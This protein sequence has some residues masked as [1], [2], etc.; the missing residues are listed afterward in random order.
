M[1]LQSTMYLHNS[2]SS[3][4]K[5]LTAFVP[6]TMACPSDNAG[7]RTYDHPSIQPH[8]TAKGNYGA[9]FGNMNKGATR[10]LAANHLP[11]AFGYR[12]VRLANITDGTS[13]SMAFG[14]QLRGSRDPAE[15]IRGSYWYD[16]PGGAWI[17][18]FVGPN[19]PVPDSL[20]AS[21]CP[22]ASNKPHLNLP[23]VPVNGASETVASRS[24]HP[25][26]LQVT[27]CDGSVRYISNNI[28]LN[29]WR[30]SGSIDAG[31]ATSP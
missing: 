29:E 16:F 18:T 26:G 10:T 25:N 19:S 6:P 27:L 7:S 8:I 30:A 23:C 12:P 17:F 24:R 15:S 5:S 20:R 1:G 3:G 9:F 14:E 13:N 2:N 31:E 28:G 4:R 21:S 22:A 11:A